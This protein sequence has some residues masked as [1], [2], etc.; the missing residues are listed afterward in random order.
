MGLWTGARISNGIRQGDR[1]GQVSGRPG[2]RADLHWHQEPHR[3]RGRA[4]PDFLRGGSN[5]AERE[6]HA[7]HSD[8]DLQPQ[9]RMVRGSQRPQLELQLG[10][11]TLPRFRLVF[12]WGRS[13]T[14]GRQPVS[15]SVEVGGTAVRPEGTPNPG[16]ILCFEL[17]PIFNF[18]V[19]PHDETKV[20]VRKQK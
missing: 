3:R 20:K 16:W 9:G 11:R 14:I 6:Q 8:P 4:K 2:G 18:H 17:S 15:L 19:G 10:K 12:K 13:F 1:I 7:H 5:S